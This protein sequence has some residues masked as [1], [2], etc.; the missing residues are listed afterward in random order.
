MFISVKQMISED[1]IREQAP[2]GFKY[3]DP[4]NVAKGIAG[5]LRHDY[6]QWLESKYPG[7]LIE[8]DRVKEGNGAQTSEVK[9][10]VFSF[11]RCD[12]ELRELIEP[13][14]NN[15]HSTFSMRE[16]DKSHLLATAS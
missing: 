9:V 12:N 5:C 2:A 15:I 13:Y 14:L 7:A 3:D 11:G 1:T 16:I 8:V 6:Y 10:V 4:W